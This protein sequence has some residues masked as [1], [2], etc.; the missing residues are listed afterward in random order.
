MDKGVIIFIY[1]FSFIYVTKT[2]ES[3][4]GNVQGRSCILLYMSKL[5]RRVNIGS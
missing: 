5:K 3:T 2:N 4:K 1:F